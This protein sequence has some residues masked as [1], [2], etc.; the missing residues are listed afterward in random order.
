MH[1]LNAKLY[2]E[3][4]FEYFLIRLSVIEQCAIVKLTNEKFSFCAQ[5]MFKKNA[6]NLLIWQTIFVSKNA[7]IY[8]ERKSKCFWK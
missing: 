7:D 5:R 2:Q 8:V 3:N 4:E 6:K 1:I